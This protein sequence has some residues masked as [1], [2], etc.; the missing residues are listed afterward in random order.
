MPTRREVLALSAST[1]VASAAP[2]NELC[3]S[4]AIDLERRIRRK[5]LSAREA[6]KAHLDQIERVNPEVNAV[7]TLVA[8]QAMA[9]AK[10]ADEDAAHGRFH[11]PL[12]GLPVLHKDLEDTAGIRTTYGS[13]LFRDF[14]PEHD[15]LLVERVKKAG[16]ITLGKTNTPE[17]GAGSQTFNTVFGTTLNP[18]DLTKTCGGSSGGSAV[19]LACGMAPLAAGSDMGGSLRNP[20]SFCAV[21]GFRSSPGRVPRVPTTSAYSTL[22]IVGPMARNVSDLA[23]FLSV[24]AGPDERCPISIHEPGSRF[25]QPLDGDFHGVRVAW[26]SGIPG[27][28]FDRRVLAVF[29]K[30]R[31]RFEQIGAT[32]EAAVPDFTDANEIFKTLRALS[33]LQQHGA[34]Y[35]KRTQLKDTVIE[36][37]ERGARLTPSEIA[38]AETKHSQ[39]YSRFGQFMGKYEFLVLPTVQVPPFDVNQPYV[40]EIEGRKLSSYIDWMESCFFITLT[41]HP[42]ISVPSGFTADGLP[43]GIQIVGRHQADFRVL[44]MARAFERANGPVRPP[45]IALQK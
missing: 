28:V 6:L 25:A 32:V 17:F 12:H 30:C 18:Y 15:S 7:V 22:S 34:K 21:V 16:A 39:L 42:A 29:D 11:G 26:A 9:Q 45:S 38:N 1:A 35:A 2:M 36:E 8:D 4:T 24:M 5:E 14:V 10:Q 41:G 27:M 33:F 13:P 43:V 37:I 44:Q 19:A 3:F 40:K 20:A 31:K 23:F